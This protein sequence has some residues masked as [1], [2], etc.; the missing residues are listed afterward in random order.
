MSKLDKELDKFF[1]QVKLE[2]KELDEEELRLTIKDETNG[3]V[4]ATIRVNIEI[5]KETKRKKTVSDLYHI[6]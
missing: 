1:N 3:D 6:V 2:L 5:N 4:Q